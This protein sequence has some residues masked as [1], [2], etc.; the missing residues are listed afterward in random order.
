MNADIMSQVLQ[1]LISFEVMAALIMGVVGGIV[2]GALPGLSATMAVALL[3][4]ITF[5]MSPVAGL[6]ML[7]AIYTAAMYGGSIS[8]IL[9]HTPGTPASA[10][11]SLDGYQMT[12]KGKGAKAIG[13]S[14]ISSM[15]GGFIS[16]LALLFL[17]P[18]LSKISLAFSAPEYFLIAVFG[19]TIIGGLAA[20]SMVKGLTAGVIGLLIGS[21][22][23]D[24]LTG[25]PRFTFGSVTLE[26]GVA[27]VPAMIGLFS[28]SQVMIQAEKR[29][30]GK[31]QKISKDALSGSVI[32]TKKEFKSIFVTIIRSSGLGTFVG[33]LPGA[34]GDIGSWV[35]YNEA[36]RFS[37][38]KDKFGKGCI[39]GVAAPEAAN[40]AVT[41]GALIPLMTLGIPGSATTAV[42][43]GGLMIQGLVPGH[44]LFT[45]HAGVTY[46][47]IFGFIIANVL[48]GIVGLAGARFFVKVSSVPEN[49]LGAVIIGLCAVGSYAI[50]N[51]IFDVW[52]MV[53]FGVIGYFMRK[54]GFHPAPV[55]LGMILGPIAENGMRQSM[56][57]AKGDLLAYY[58]GRPI[59]LVLILLII[60]TL[61]SPVY[62]NWRKKKGTRN[63]DNDGKIEAI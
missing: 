17:A 56:L 36:K 13:I 26:S 20:K 39:E 21:V 23:V 2:I 51:N 16:A 48:L 43:L 47:V 9:I 49:I 32:P 5:A 31:Q 10:A 42:L 11:T 55:V 14:T 33:M 57:M 24:I 52:I 8:A 18:P 54:T 46:S 3:I 45:T 41:G 12:K 25:Y 59:C 63:T 40:N 7:T 61:L 6:T 60:L 50:N 22:G 37:K 53:V 27:L 28:L 1:N 58:M 4:P 62:M 38:D 44:E 30:K 34:G 29:G 19:L 15:I 35:A